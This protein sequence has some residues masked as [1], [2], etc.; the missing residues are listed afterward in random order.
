MFFT[1]GAGQRV[2]VHEKGWVGGGKGEAR[3]LGVGAGWGGG[4]REGGASILEVL[5]G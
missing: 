5:Y 1:L 3:G 2:C 4:G